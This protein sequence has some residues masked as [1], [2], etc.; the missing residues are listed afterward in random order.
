MRGHASCQSPRP[1]RFK[2]PY[3][4]RVCVYQEQAYTWVHICFT[5]C[6]VIL[7]KQTLF[8]CHPI[9]IRSSLVATKKLKVILATAMGNSMMKR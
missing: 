7:I 4:Y 9:I 8:E 6:Q 1:L 2:P 3:I 5:I